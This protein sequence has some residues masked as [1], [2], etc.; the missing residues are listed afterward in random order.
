MNRKR[1][2]RDRSKG[3]P[4]EILSDTYIAIII[5]FFTAYTFTRDYVKD[6]SNAVLALILAVFSV[7]FLVICSDITINIL[8]NKTSRGNNMKYGRQLHNHLQATPRYVRAILS[9]DGLKGVFQI[10]TIILA[11]V[12]IILTFHIIALTSN[13]VPNFPTTE[14]RIDTINT[15]SYIDGGHANN[16][17]YDVEYSIKYSKM[18]PPNS[19]NFSIPVPENYGG[20]ALLEESR[21]LKI[22]GNYFKNNTIEIEN[23]NLFNPFLL[24]VVYVSKENHDIRELI[25]D[26]P[27]P[28]IENNSILYDS[29]FVKIENIGG[30]DIKTVILNSNVTNWINVDLIQLDSTSWINQPIMIYDNGFPVMQ[31]KINGRGIITWKISSINSGE[32]K[33]Y[34]FKKIDEY[35][36]KQ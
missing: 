3:A 1:R 9:K 13:D 6:Q 15:Y 17:I 22:K 28:D 12:A 34:H 35:T 21:G 23:E 18:S 16:T 10:S 36:S 14:Y 2:F 29:F 5:L 31:T 30:H 25:T 19:Y 20:I 8:F 26:K 27:L 11:I 7:L 24:H 33:I 32:Q 4:L